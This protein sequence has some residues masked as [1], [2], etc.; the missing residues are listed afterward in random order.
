MKSNELPPAYGSNPNTLSLFE[1]PPLPNG[2]DLRTVYSDFIR[3][4]YSHTRNFFIQ[5]TPNGHVIW[6][7]LQSKSVIIFCH[8]NGWDISQQSFLSDCAVRAGILSQGEV[9]SRTGYVTEGE[10]SVHYAF[11]HLS[12]RSWLQPGL[13][14]AVVD[15]GG[16]TVDSN[17]YKCESIDPLKLKEVH[18]SECVQVRLH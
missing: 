5:S 6:K 18:R 12:S 14:V 15:A 2:V 16:S 9:D 17:L 3:Y 10:A 4:L 1:V 7:R 11:A 8:P 13:M